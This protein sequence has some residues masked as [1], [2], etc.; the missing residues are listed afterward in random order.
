MLLERSQARD[1]YLACLRVPDIRLKK[2]RCRVD[3]HKDKKKTHLYTLFALKPPVQS[4]YIG[5]AAP[6]GL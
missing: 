2:S 4:E 3:M 6:N 1:F 5:G